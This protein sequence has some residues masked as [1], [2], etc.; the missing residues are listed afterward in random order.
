MASQ[1]EVKMPFTCVAKK[2]D[3]AWNTIISRGL[4]GAFSEKS[5]PP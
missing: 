5:N 1:A 4:H 2:K 3:R